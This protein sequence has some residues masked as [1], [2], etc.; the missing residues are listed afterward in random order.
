[1]EFDLILL[2]CKIL[3]VCTTY[4]SKLQS[5]RINIHISVGL[6]VRAVLKEAVPTGSLF[7]LWCCTDSHCEA[8]VPIGSQ[9][10][11]V[12]VLYKQ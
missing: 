7:L 3:Y 11:S 8:N 1:M 2:L 6:F 9:F 4:Y 12:M 10:I 5:G